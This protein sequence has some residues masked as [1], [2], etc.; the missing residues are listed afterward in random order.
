MLSSII[1]LSQYF[2]VRV[3]LHDFSVDNS[4]VSLSF[5]FAN[6]LNN[7]NDL[8]DSNDSNDSNNSNVS[9]CS[10]VSRSRV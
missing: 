2:V 5:S 3:I 4:L 7:T 8:N 1:K 10:F 9:R 6:N